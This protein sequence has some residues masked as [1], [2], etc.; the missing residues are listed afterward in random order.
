MA[1]TVRINDV[2]YSW[3]MIQLTSPGLTGSNDA[4]ASIL[5]GVTAI[6]WNIQRNTSVNYGLGGRPVNRG[7]GNIAYTAQI[8]MDYNAISQIRG[9]YPSLLDLGEFDLVI[10]FANPV[11][12]AADAAAAAE[13]LQTHTVVLKQCFFNEDG[14]DVSQDDTTI[15]KTFDL[16]PFSINIEPVQ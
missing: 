1:D 10:S 2:A 5:S 4:N 11:V 12:G 8:T 16:N 9:A 3:S 14:M 7:F 13:D 15:T 6:N